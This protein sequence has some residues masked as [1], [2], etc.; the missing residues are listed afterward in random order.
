MREVS[1]DLGPIIEL[2]QKS[3]DS[4]EKLKEDFSKLLNVK[5]E[6]LHKIDIVTALDNSCYI[7]WTDGKQRKVYL[8]DASEGNWIV[9]YHSSEG[10][11]DKI[12]GVGCIESCEHYKQCTSDYRKKFG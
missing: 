1:F 3:Y 12:L 9:P 11:K 5:K 4:I 10:L 7:C 6:E 8:F 2:P